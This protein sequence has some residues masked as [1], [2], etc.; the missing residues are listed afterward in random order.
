LDIST[1]TVVAPRRPTLRQRIAI[2]SALLVLYALSEVLGVVTLPGYRSTTGL[3]DIG[4]YYVPSLVSLVGAARAEYVVWLGTLPLE[5]FF[6]GIIVSIVLTGRGIRLGA[7]LYVMYLLHWLCLHATTL[8]PPDEI[9]WKFPEGVFT[10]GRPTASD[11]WFSGHVANAFVIALAA[12]RSRSALRA[13]AWAL[14]A[15]EILLVLSARTHYTIDVIGG[16]FVG[17]SIHRISVD[18]AR[19]FNS[20]AAAV[21]VR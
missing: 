10:F 4:H 21:A 9:V 2:A 14:F 16:V 7:C 13:F 11:F 12:A 20:P 3:R 18:V 15:F 5:L 17:Y 1:E 19:R 6:I 8:P